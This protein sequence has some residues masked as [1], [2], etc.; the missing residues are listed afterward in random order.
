MMA[1]LGAD[2]NLEANKLPRLECEDEEDTEGTD[3]EASGVN[4]E[5]ELSTA[6]GEF[7]KMQTA[8]AELKE[9]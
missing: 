2:L 7:E 9:K 8:F 6:R 4:A 5:K 3:V 1:R